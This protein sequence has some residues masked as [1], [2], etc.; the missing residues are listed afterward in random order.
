M[1]K[2]VLIQQI[3]PDP[4]N[5]PTFGQVSSPTDIMDSQVYAHQHIEKVCKDFV[6]G[7]CA[8]P[9]M[10]GFGYTLGGGLEITI[11]PGHVLD[12]QGLSYQLDDLANVPL[13]LSPADPNNMRI[14]LVVGTLVVDNP[15]LPEAMPFVQLRTQAQLNAGVA[16][17]P[18]AQYTEPTELHTIA[19]ISVLQ[20]TASV[21]P[22]PQP[23]GANQVL[24]YTVAVPAGLTVLGTANIVDNRPLLPSL[25]VLYD[26]VEK[27]EQELASNDSVT[28]PIPASEVSIGPGAGFLSGLTDQDGW[29]YV[30][31]MG[32]TDNY[33]PLTRPETGQI[34]PTNGQWVSTQGYIQANPNVDTN[35]NIPVIEIPPNMAVAFS[36]GVQ[37]VNINNLPA[38]SNPR[39]VNEASAGATESTTNVVPLLL[40]SLL[41]I[42]SDGGGNWEQMST[43]TLPASTIIYNRRAAARDSQ[44]IEFFGAGAFSST[45]WETF[46]TIGLTLTQR[47]FAGGATLPNPIVFAA[48]CGSDTI[49]LATAPPGNTAA[50]FYTLNAVSGALTLCANQPS[51]FVAIGAQQFWGDLI[52]TNIIF[53]AAIGTAS[54]VWAYEIYHA[55]T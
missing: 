28:L 51:G 43:P 23:L 27:I 46:D 29:A 49:L 44:Y 50:Q 13:T 16:P 21:N 52:A 33:D 36:D 35:G 54:A 17:Y 19:Q 9:V 15:S 3:Q 22:T 2:K 31:N 39:L 4:P 7:D 42:E 45:L 34:G 26:Q 41:N 37:P 18:P 8:E 55:D 12:A 30:G 1:S 38:A 47:N 25:C 53:V 10:H 32:A 40:S 48:P 14:D 5:G 11:G 24:L 6:V 20:G